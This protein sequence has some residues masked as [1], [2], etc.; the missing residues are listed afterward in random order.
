[1]Q[2]D[3]VISN[4]APVGPAGPRGRLTHHSGVLTEHHEHKNLGGECFG[5]SNA[6]FRTSRGEQDRLGLARQG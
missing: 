2:V 1:M 6:D 3:F 5:R 4:A